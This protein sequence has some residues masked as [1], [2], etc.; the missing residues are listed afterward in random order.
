MRLEPADWIGRDIDLEIDRPTGSAHP[1]YPDLIYPINYGFVPGTLADDGESI[2][3]YLVGDDQSL[4][5]ARGR[6][7]AVLRRDDD[8]AA[9]LVVALNEVRSGSAT[10]TAEAIRA[11]VEFQERY[12]T[13]RVLTGG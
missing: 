12:F 4:P 6:V 11:A 1:D 5:S 9:K 13:S 3:A 2:E 7:I 8:V 10:Y